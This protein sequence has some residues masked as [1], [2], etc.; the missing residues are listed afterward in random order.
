MSKSN[1]RNFERKAS[2]KLELVMQSWN[3]TGP[4][5]GAFI[6]NKGIYSSDLE[7]WKNEMIE[8]LDGRRPLY[9]EAVRK[10]DSQVA[11]L[12]LKLRQTEAILEAKKK[13]E[14]LWLEEAPNVQQTSKGKS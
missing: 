11:S 2:E 8:G 3:L 10:H 14:L 6:R 13:L 7:T 9:K 5:L 1:D 12:E 4:A